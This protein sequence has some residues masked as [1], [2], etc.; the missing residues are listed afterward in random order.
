MPE[1][2]LGG[3]A[4]PPKED[5]SDAPAGA[6]ALAQEIPGYCHVQPLPLDQGMV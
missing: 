6:L 1:Q 2:N 4:R 5:F 3:P